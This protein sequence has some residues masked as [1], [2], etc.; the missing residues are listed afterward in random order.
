MFLA[1]VILLPVTRNRFFLQA[2]S[3]QGTGSTIS[4]D[5]TAPR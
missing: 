2:L 1:R 5:S 4:R 3:L